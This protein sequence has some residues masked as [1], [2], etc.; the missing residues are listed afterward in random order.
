MFCHTLLG[1]ILGAVFLTFFLCS[2]VNFSLLLARKGVLGLILEVSKKG[3]QELQ[4]SL[5]VFETGGE[6]PALRHLGALGHSVYW[7]IPS[8]IT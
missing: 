2:G 7:L 5:D 6:G 3:L 8:W 1:L 4:V